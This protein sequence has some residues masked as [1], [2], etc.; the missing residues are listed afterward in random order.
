MKTVFNDLSLHKPIFKDDRMGRRMTQ[1]HE[2]LRRI[3]S[4]MDSNGPHHKQRLGPRLS[5][6]TADPHSYENQ[7]NINAARRISVQHESSRSRSNAIH[8]DEM[9][10]RILQ[11][12]PSLPHITERSYYNFHEVINSADKS[13]LH[14]LSTV[15]TRA[16]SDPPE[17]HIYY[18]QE[19]ALRLGTSF[20]LATNK[21][22]RPSKQKT[23]HSAADSGEE[24]DDDFVD[25]AAITSST[26]SD[27]E[28]V[29][30]YNLRDSLKSN[31]EDRNNSRVESFP[32]SNYENVTPTHHSGSR[33][34]FSN[35]LD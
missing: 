3:R 18:N 15:S 12:S 7:S 23:I 32:Q 16:S 11:A 13:R 25:V 9:N 28:Q 10:S 26:S 21:E 4:K 14:Q 27:P 33:Y 20:K 34:I 31:K 22:L 29:I 30:Y 35:I 2:I 17:D 5:L 1:E 19:T 24:S 8:G 6:N